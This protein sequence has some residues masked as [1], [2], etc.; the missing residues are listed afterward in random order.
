MILN[1]HLKI[2]P[3][4]EQGQG[5]SSVGLAVRETSPVP[6]AAVSQD[7]TQFKVL[8][9]QE[10]DDGNEIRN[11]NCYFHPPLP[12]N[13]FRNIRYANYIIIIMLYDRY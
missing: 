9:S 7:E 10:Q 13:R 2:V 4:L 1:G 8:P 3:Q 5:T 6:T 12:I 11:N